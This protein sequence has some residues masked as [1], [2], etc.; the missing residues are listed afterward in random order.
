MF[1]DSEERLFVLELWIRKG[2]MEGCHHVCVH[3]LSRFAV[4]MWFQGLDKAAWDGLL[5]L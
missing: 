1:K 2:A 5:K 3:I 4:K